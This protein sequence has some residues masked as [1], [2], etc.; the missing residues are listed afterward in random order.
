MIDRE[1]EYFRARSGPP[2]DHGAAHAPQFVNRV[3]KASGK[4]GG[5]FGSCGPVTRPRGRAT[6]G[7]G[8]A[9]AR[10][11]GRG[12]D[13]RARRVVIKTRL[14]NLQRAGVRSTEKHL[15]YIERDGVTREGTHGQLYGPDI[16]RADADAFEQRSRGDRHQFRFILSADDALELGDLKTFTRAQMKQVER[17][18]DTRLDWVAVDH[19]DTD[20]PHTHIVLRGRDDRGADLVIARDYIGRGMRSRA[21]ELATQWLGPR[22]KREIEHIR[23]RETTQD[24]WTSLD[25]A[26]AAAAR[27]GVVELHRVPGEF[28]QRRHRVLLV[29]RLQHLAELGLAEKDRGARWTLRSEAEHTLRAMGERGDIVRTLQRSFAGRQL[30]GPARWTRG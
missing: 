29:G 26:L 20:N 5:A 19:W 4:V 9:A 17:D 16:D 25:Q 27:D 11:A 7:R 10:L 3:L 28:G 23:Q 1:D 21:S 13:H 24:R 22:T 12:L 30:S 6:S 18:L 14:V 8:A 2:R 15:R